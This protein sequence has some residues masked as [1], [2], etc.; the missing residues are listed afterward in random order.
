MDDIESAE[1]GEPRA[2]PRPGRKIV[3]AAP[4]VHVNPA[5]PGQPGDLYAAAPAVH[6]NPA[7]PGQPGDLYA[8]APDVN[9]AKPPKTCE[10]ELKDKDAKITELRKQLEDKDA[11]ITQLEKQITDLQAEL[12]VPEWVKSL[13]QPWRGPFKRFDR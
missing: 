13:Y 4:A 11:K 1:S 7:A 9:P 8:A 6:V 2:K 12:N 5:A 3:A 10:E